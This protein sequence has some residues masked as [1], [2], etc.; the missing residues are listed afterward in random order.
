MDKGE[1]PNLFKS[2]DIQN[3]LGGF[4][5]LSGCWCGL[6]AV[7][8]GASSSKVPWKNAFKE[9]TQ[10]VSTTPVARYRATTP[11]ILPPSDG[12]APA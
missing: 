6:P 9:R 7:A 3:K 5:G 8:P 4:Q 2:Q 1:F 11:T 12:M 10:T